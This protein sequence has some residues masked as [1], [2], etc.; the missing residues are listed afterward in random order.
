MSED[1]QASPADQAI[2]ALEQETKKAEGQAEELNEEAEKV[3][4]AFDIDSADKVKFNG[5][6]YTP[7]ELNQMLLMQ[8]DYTKKTQALAQE[9]KYVDNLQYDLDNVRR[10]PQLAED[11]KKLY[12]EKFHG[13]LDIILNNPASNDESEDDLSDVEIKTL[14]GE[15]EALKNKLGEYDSKFHEEKVEATQ[16]HLDA[17]F[18]KYQSKYDLADEDAVVNRAQRLLEENRDNPHFE[19]TDGHWERLFRADHEMRDKRYSERHKK[20][21]ESQAE[22][23][24][25]AT[26]GGPGGVAPGREKK[27]MTF[28]EATEMAVQ[29]F[30][31]S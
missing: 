12:P 16:A 22:K 28:D 27:R 9:R 29:D 25:L 5:K 15:I 2:E 20:L 6:E 10:N 21:L 3:A 26:D 13:Y 31:G 1:A 30:G 24:K 23:G 7:D 11:F 18:E 17:V 19:L 8:S 14:K 4:E